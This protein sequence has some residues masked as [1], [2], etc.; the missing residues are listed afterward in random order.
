MWHDNEGN[1]RD[2]K[3]IAALLSRIEGMEKKITLLTWTCVVWWG[4]FALFLF[5]FVMKCMNKV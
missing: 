4:L 3:L 5:A 1:A 2:K